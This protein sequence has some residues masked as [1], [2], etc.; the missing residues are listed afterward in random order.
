MALED[1]HLDLSRLQLFSFKT[2][3][4]GLIAGWL[5]SLWVSFGPLSQVLAWMCL[6]DLG[7]LALIAL[8]DWHID[9]IQWR[10]EALAKAAIVMV[11]VGA[12]LLL[13]ID[14][15]VPPELASIVTGF[16]VWCEFAAVLKKA[17]ACGLR[18]PDALVSLALKIQPK[19]AGDDEIK[20]LGG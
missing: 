20:K 8:R 6:L 5:L 17:R 3:S 1:Y 2:V 4:T 9:V 18:L 15:R 10:Y 11:V 7:G 14:P 12:H 13:S 19:S 16:F